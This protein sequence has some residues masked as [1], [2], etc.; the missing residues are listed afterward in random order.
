MKVLQINCLYGSKSTGTI[1]RHLQDFCFANSMDAYVAFSMAD[2]PLSQIKNSYRIG[3]PV[4]AK[5]HALLSRIA[6]KQSYYNHITTWLFLRYLDQVKPDVVHLHNVHSNYIHLN[7]LLA[8][9]AKRDIATVITLHDCWFFTGGCFHY[10]NA[11]CDKWQRG[12]GHCPKRMLDTKAYFWDTSA[13]ILRD[14]A[15]YLNAIPRLV[16]VGCSKW[17]SSECRKSIIGKRE[18]ISIYN[19]FD[20]SVYK[21]SDSNWREKLGLSDKFVII[22]PAN[23]WLSSVNKDTFKYFINNMPDDIVMVLFGC[24]DVC[25][26]S[27]SGNVIKIGYISDPC[28]MA[29]LYSMA[30]VFVNCSREDTLSSLNIECQACGTPVVTYEAT[31][32]KETV[33]N[34]CSFAIETGN[35]KKLFDKM[36]EVKESGKDNFS[37]ACCERIKKKFELNRNIMAYM[38][39]YKSF[40]S[41]IV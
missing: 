36:L 19:G 28:E 14:R 17:I 40:D 11:N 25:N 39:L 18:I 1:M 38:D 34:K 26:I 5:L 16:I 27:Y 32:N 13:S 29:K 21:P 24:K 6:G 3:N 22:G 9:L 37:K 2:R 20:L 41:N 30:D 4:T 15:Y 33:D 8:Y 23:K 35:F 12:C 31:G 7:M 10:S